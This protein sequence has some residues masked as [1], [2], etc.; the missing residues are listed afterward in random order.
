MVQ[1]LQAVEIHSLHQ[2]MRDIATGIHHLGE[3][4]RNA[5]A[6]VSKADMARGMEQLQIDLIRLKSALR[7]LKDISLSPSKKKDDGQLLPSLLGGMA[8][9]VLLGKF[10]GSKLQMDLLPFLVGMDLVL[11]PEQLK[12]RKSQDDSVAMS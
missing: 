6:D 2:Q 10:L 12:S 4:L 5:G 9:G 8:M 7:H 11:G 1:P 3:D